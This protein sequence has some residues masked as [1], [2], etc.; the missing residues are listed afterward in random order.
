MNR[1]LKRFRKL[2]AKQDKGRTPLLEESEISQFKRQ[3]GVRLEKSE[4]KENVYKIKKQQMSSE[5]NQ[6]TAQVH[7][8]I[9]HDPFKTRTFKLMDLNGSL[10]R[11]GPLLKRR[12]ASK[13]NSIK[14][15]ES[16]KQAVAELDQVIAYAEQFLLEKTEAPEN[17]N[18]SSSQLKRQDGIILSKAEQDLCQLFLRRNKELSKLSTLDRKVV[19]AMCKLYLQLANSNQAPPKNN[20]NRSSFSHELRI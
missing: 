3:N 11:S 12:I 9:N 1:F 7:Q 2:L 6:V 4:K 14:L 15:E 18:K 16:E 20:T 19:A 10:S 5:L 8:P 17:L 13:Q